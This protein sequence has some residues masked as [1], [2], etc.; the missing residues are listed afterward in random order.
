ME[1]M[2]TWRKL[3]D[4]ITGIIIAIY[5]VFGLFIQVLFVVMMQMELWQQVATVLP[6][7]LS[8]LYSI[9]R[10]IEKRRTRIKD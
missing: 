1:V 8:M 2:L 10:L 6:F 5:V 3:F 4:W 9:W 7:I